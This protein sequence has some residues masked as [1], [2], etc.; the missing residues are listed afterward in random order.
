MGAS[1]VTDLVFSSHD[2]DEQAGFFKQIRLLL[3]KATTST[4]IQVANSSSPEVQMP[5]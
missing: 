1:A 3:A 2:S 4:N 5:S